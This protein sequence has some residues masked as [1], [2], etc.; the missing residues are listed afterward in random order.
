MPK[1]QRRRLLVCKSERAPFALQQ[2][3]AFGVWLQ[4]AWQFGSP[5]DGRFTTYVFRHSDAHEPLA[6]RKAITSLPCFRLLLG[7]AI[8]SYILSDTLGPQAAALRRHQVAGK[9]VNPQTDEP[10]AGVDV[11]LLAARMQRGHA[12]GVLA[13][14]RV[15]LT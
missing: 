3:T 2:Q 1:P 13:W 8:I 10:V 4:T 14:K 11:L 15:L 7:Q 9:V 12:T 5:E 6:I